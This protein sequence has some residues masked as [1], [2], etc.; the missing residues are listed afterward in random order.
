MAFIRVPPDSTGKRVLTKEHTV[1]GEVVQVQ[2]MHIVDE[3]DPN[4]AMH[5]DQRG[6]A[7]IRFSEGQP[8]LA[9][10][11][12]LRVSDMNVLGVYEA[13]LDTYDALFSIETSVAGG[14]S[15][16]DPVQGGTLLQVDG[17][18]GSY[19]KRTTN[20]YHYYLPGTSTTFLFYGGPGDTGKA[21]CVR[22][23]GMYDDNDGLFFEL[24]GTEI[25]LV[26]R[27][28]TSGTV[29]D[30]EVSSANW[31]GVLAGELDPSQIY[32]T[33][34]VPQTWW[35]DYSLSGR[36]RFGVYNSTG[37]RIIIHEFS[38][39]GQLPF[40][41]RGTLPCRTEIFNTTATGSP[42]VLRE[43]SMA[44]YSEATF[45][46]FTF[47]RYSGGLIS[48][49]VDVPNKLLATV[50]ALPTVNGKQNSV[51]IFPE[52]LNIYANH[53]VALTLAQ[54]VTAT[55]QTWTEIPTSVIE[56]AY[57]GSWAPNDD[58]IYFKTVFCDAGVTVLNV[59][60]WFE[61]NDEGLL[62]RA[63][64]TPVVWAFLGTPLTAQH[65]DVK[66]NVGWRE[67]W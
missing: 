62:V 38:P 9:G 36:A 8:A 12:S 13:T 32:S 46:Q 55:G 53:P 24:D 60:Q 30:T 27:A 67:L 33:L 50:R 7:L 40:L 37:E 65:P 52:T 23:A 10:F 15:I 61:L 31:T 58:T 19:V 22:R 28:S 25:K 66:F 43:F 29:V 63:D 5:V 6:A 14:E 47:W 41:G 17:S 39:S 20:R 57:D 42:S 4:H 16:Y 26:V 2:K 64:G 35:F 34:N 21:G 51:Q 59:S 56:A 44:V 1:S 54:D 49:H 18:A 45:D 48:A 11:A 3:V